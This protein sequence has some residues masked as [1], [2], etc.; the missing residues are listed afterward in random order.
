M[1]RA[2]RQFDGVVI[3]IGANADKADSM[4]SAQERCRTIEALYSN[5]PRVRV[6]VYTELTAHAAARNGCSAIVR[7]VRSVQDFEYERNMA[8]VN[9]RLN[10]METILLMTLPELACVSSSIVRELDSYG[11]DI[12][13]FMPRKHQD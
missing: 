2:L 8:D 10:G 9:R 12:S 7:G 13:Q 5:E 11:C 6:V 1:D 3:A 4:N